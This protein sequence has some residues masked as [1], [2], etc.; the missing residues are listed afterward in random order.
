MIDDD[1]YRLLTFAHACMQAME[2]IHAILPD[3]RIVS[4]VEVCAWNPAH[5]NPQGGPTVYTITC[6]QPTA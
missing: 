3:G 1:A 4:D 5:P 6:P 2:R